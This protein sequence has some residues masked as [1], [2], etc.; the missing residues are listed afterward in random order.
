LL[1]TSAS[2][3]FGPPLRYQWNKNGVPLDATVA[4]TKEGVFFIQSVKVSDMGFYT[5]TVTGSGISTESAVAIVTVD[6]LTASRLINVSTRGLVPAGGALTPGF[7]LRGAGS[8]SLV[9]RAV[10]PTL[11]SAF[12]VPGVLSDPK[13]E[14]IPQGSVASV[15][16]NDNWIAGGALENASAAVG[17]FSLPAG[18]KDAALQAS[19]AGGGSSG[20]SVRIA[21][22]GAALAGIALAEVYDT[23]SLAAPVRLVNVSTLGFAGLDAEALTPGF[24]IGGTAPKTVL[25]RAVGPGLAA[26]NVPGTLADPALT[27]TPL[28]KTFAI[29]G[30]NDWGDDGRAATLS[31]AFTSVGAFSLPVGSKD[32]A[33]VVRLPPGGY[34]V[35]VTGAARTTGAVLVEVYDLNP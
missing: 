20:Y 19:L 35:Q 23:E 7:V 12:G 4:G 5:V 3:Y 18:S 10:G 11:G 16:A 22:G 27:I 26:F 15:L 25:V 33:L 24:V 13:L 29:A 1:S 14:V 6:D 8:K 30:N 31:A 32:A 34:T 9:I 21:P 17:A 2:F 28:G